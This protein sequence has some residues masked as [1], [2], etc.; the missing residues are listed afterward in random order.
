MRA[1]HTAT[2][3]KK[4]QQQQKIDFKKETKEK[5]H[6]AG[7]ISNVR[8]D[9]NKSTTRRRY[10]W[11]KNH[12]QQPHV[13]PSDLKRLPKTWE[14]LVALGSVAHGGVAVPARLGAPGA[15]DALVHSR[16]D[17]V[18]LFDVQLGEG[19]VVEHRGLADVT[20][21]G[22]VHDV[23]ARREERIG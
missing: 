13:E 2:W 11:G 20:E 22:S 3:E 16:L 4:K 12:R 8:N 5:R 7:P 17:A 14:G 10:T 6:G 21:G 1:V 18:V 9:D 23:P 19:V 15:H